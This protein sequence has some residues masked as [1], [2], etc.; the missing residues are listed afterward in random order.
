[1]NLMHEAWA[2][3]WAYLNSP[4]LLEA[5][6][7]S[8]FIL[9]LLVVLAVSLK[10]RTYGSMFLAA[11][12]NMPGTI[13]HESAHFIVGLLLWAKPTSFSLF[14]RKNGDAYTMGSVGFCN[15]KFYNAIPAAMAPLLLLWAAYWLN[16]YYL[17]HAHITIWSYLLFILLETVIIENAVPSA[18]DF[19][20]ALS[21]PLGILL[22]GGLVLALLVGLNV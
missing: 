22:Y 5:V 4:Q 2:D 21:R 20:V 13:L 7:N 17:S 15:I 14:P 18:T 1:M 16:G 8:R 12:V 10:H 3:F 11:L 19:N 9:I 6:L